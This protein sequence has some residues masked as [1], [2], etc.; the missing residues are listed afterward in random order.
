MDP[1]AEVV[2]SPAVGADPLVDRVVEEELTKRTRGLYFENVT[3]EKK[4]LP[5]PPGGAGG[6]GGAPLPKKER[7][8]NT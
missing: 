7:K 1:V 8:V 2:L 4:K 6:G 5:P 3:V